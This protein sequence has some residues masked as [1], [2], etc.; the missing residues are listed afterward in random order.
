MRIISSPVKDMVF[1][2]DSEPSTKKR[3]VNLSLDSALVE[4]ARAQGVNLSRFLEAHLREALREHRE[5]AWR[6]ENREA[7]RQYN[8][9]V[10]ERG[11]FGDRFRRF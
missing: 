4:D 1:A 2:H 7:I 3:A 9:A 11:S 8:E 10:A 5:Q 6:E